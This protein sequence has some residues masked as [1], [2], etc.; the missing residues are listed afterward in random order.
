MNI[1]RYF[2]PTVVLLL[3]QALAV[4]SQVKYDV[5]SINPDLIKNASAVV[6]FSETTLSVSSL[7]SASLEVRQVITILNERGRGMSVYFGIDDRFMTYRFGG[8]TIYD[9]NGKKVKSFGYS[10]L[11]PQ[12]TFSG[13]TLY[14][15]VKYKSLDPEYRTYP[16]TAEIKYT[17]DLK[18]S[19]SFPD[20]VIAEDNSVSTEKSLLSVTAPADFEIRFFEQNMP[21]K[22]TSRKEGSRAIYEWSVENFRALKEEPFALPAER[23][24]PAVFIVPAKFEI[25]GKKGSTSTW[26]EFGQ[27]FADLNYNRNILPENFVAQ[28]RELAALTPDTTEIVRKLY[29]M[30]QEKTRYVSVQIGIGGWQPIEA[31]K[32]HETSYGDCKALSNYMKSMLD[33]AGIKA[34]YTI[35]KAGAESRYINSGFPSNQFNHVI[36]CVPGENDTIWLECTSQ[37]IPFNYLGTFSDDRDVLLVTENGGRLS[38]TRKYS[39]ENI[40]SRNAVVKLDPAGSGQATVS[41]VYSHSFYDAMARVLLSDNESQKRLLTGLISLPGFTLTEFT[42]SQPDRNMPVIKEDLRLNLK[43]YATV[44]GNRMILPVNL[45]SRASMLPQSNDRYSEILINREESTIDTITYQIPPGYTPGS[46]FSPVK[47]KSEF[48]SY[49]ASLVSNGNQIIYVRKQT[50]NKGNYPPAKYP[51]FTDFINKIASADMVKVILQ[52]Q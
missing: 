8:L 24:S 43:G 46:A 15:D 11:E 40:K 10:D 13:S 27:F 52:K 33:A 28:I 32:V 14:S 41:T 16:F 4:R 47:L 21:R 3:T 18:G 1:A 38:H 34:Y 36:V 12:I 2:I 50:M 25:A 22:G 35:V 5:A 48:G 26:E 44:M 49:E 30:M 23:L 42:V 19:F 29:S 31:M 9:Q 7:N 51:D 20:W 39:S 45:L 37:R 17:I 6:R